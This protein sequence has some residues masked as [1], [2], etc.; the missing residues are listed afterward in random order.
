MTTGGDPEHGSGG[1]PRMAITWGN[2][3]VRTMIALMIIASFSAFGARPAH[4]AA[5]SNDNFPGATITGVTSS[6]AGT[7]VDA[8]SQEGEP[9]HDDCSNESVWYTWTAPSTGI[10]TF[11]TS[12]SN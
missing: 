11:S 5:P 2:V 12:G 6:I 10:T 1:G 4:A 3:R 9:C 7:N 8:T